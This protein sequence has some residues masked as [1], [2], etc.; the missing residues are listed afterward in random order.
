MRY[1]VPQGSILS[2]LLFLLYINDFQ[3]TIS[4]KS[5]PTL[6]AGDTSIIISNPTPTEFTK[7]IN[8]ILFEINRSFQS[9]LLFLNYD[10]TYFMQFLPKKNK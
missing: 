10:E 1:G 9:N 6:F 2:L 4:N 8:Q 5:N 3:K 7:N